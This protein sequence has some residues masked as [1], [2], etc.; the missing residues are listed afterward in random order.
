MA[1]DRTLLLP[2]TVNANNAAE[3][4]AQYQLSLNGDGPL[5][6]DGSTLTSFD[7][8]VLALLLALRRRAQ[9]IGKNLLCQNLS[10]N[11][12]KLALLYG[13]ESLI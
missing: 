1:G 12:R 4:L 8:S 6:I 7:S 11:L 5:T 13:V 3:L 10:P 9:V 2:A